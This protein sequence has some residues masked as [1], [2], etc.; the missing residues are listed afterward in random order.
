M[1]QKILKDVFLEIAEKRGTGIHGLA[2]II[3]CN[4]ALLYQQ[5]RTGNF[6]RKSF[7]KMIDKLG[8]SDAEIIAIVRTKSAT[9]YAEEIL[10][11]ENS[12]NNEEK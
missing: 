9:E 3:G 10:E 7:L 6:T 8:L 5:I 2:D 11:K 4:N 1:K 12:T